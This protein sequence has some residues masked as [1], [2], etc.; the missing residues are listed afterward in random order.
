MLAKARIRKHFS[1][2]ASSY[3]N[4]ALFQKRCGE[5]MLKEVFKKEKNPQRIL[6]IGS[7][8]GRCSFQL[9]TV[10]PR[11]LVLGFD[12]AEGMVSYAEKKKKGR[13]DLSRLLFCQ[14]DAEDLPLPDGYFDV[15]IS[16]LTYQWANDLSSAFREVFRV[17]RVDGSFY[18]TTLGEGSLRELS[19]SFAEAHRRL[20]GHSLPHGQDFVEKEEL[21]ETLRQINFSR[22]SIR[23]F[24]E[25]NHYPNVLDFLKWLKKVGANNA[26]REMAPGRSNPKLLR[27][28][29]KVYE[30]NYRMNGSIPVSFQVILGTGKKIS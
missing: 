26:L 24:R 17:L 16:N 3:D 22:L 25:N 23:T 7:G 19:S 1:R 27:E 14:A 15:V 13:E 8:T 9:A 21:E 20:K 10:Y 4:L 6:D 29:V 2:A 12:L 28:M 18:F 30:K 5:R 11:T